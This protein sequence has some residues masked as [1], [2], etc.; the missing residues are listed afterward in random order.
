MAKKAF[1]L[2]LKNFK[3]FLPIILLNFIVGAIIIDS[4]KEVIIAYGGIM[5]VATWLIALFLD[6]HIIAGKKVKF[7]DGLYN[8]MAP[9]F[10]TLILL[11]VATIQCVP[12]FFLIVAYTSAVETD[13]LLTMGYAIMFI[14]FAL[15]MIFITSYLLS[16]TLIALIIVSTPGMYPFEALRLAEDLVKGK[17]LK[18]TLA[19]L[20]LMVGVGAFFGVGVGAITLVELGLKNFDFMK[21]ISLVPGAALI[22]GCFAIIYI[23]T[24]LYF[25]YKQMI[26][27]VKKK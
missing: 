27:K 6:R 9:L 21:G 24:Y 7:R 20:R 19:N 17:R 14:L 11:M 4:Q 10:S 13:F 5:I 3:I 26:A 2:L 8:A 23:A 25:S 15:L 1:D 18:V 12:I 16:S 22:L